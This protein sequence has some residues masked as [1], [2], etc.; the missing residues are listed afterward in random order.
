[1]AWSGTT[2]PDNRVWVWIDY[3]PINGDTPA[4]TY[5]AADITGAS[6]A[7]DVASTSTRGFFVTANPATVTAT[8]DNPPAKFNWCA[9]GSGAPPKAVIINADGDYSLKGTPPFTVNGT[10][11]GAD[12]TTFGAGTCITSITDLTGNPAGLIPDKPTVSTS[13]PA[14]R[15]GAGAVTLTAT[16]SGGVTTAMTY[17]WIVGGEPAETTADGSQTTAV[18]GSTTYSVTATNANGCT[19]AAATGTITVNPL[20]ESLSLT[21]SPAAI[22][23]GESTTLTASA[24][25]AASYSL[26]GS[27]WQTTNTFVVSP[28]ETTIY[29]LY[30]RTSAGC[31]ASKTTAATVTVNP[32]PESLSLTAST[33]T[34]CI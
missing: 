29:T 10:T 19:S 33:A 16:A 18:A 5:G 32:L 28:T 1:V 26:D 13:N 9:Y 34:I 27:A 14:A 6:P 23:N 8:L 25:D 12:V 24:S 2:T 7:A 20:P 15:C 17:T 30:G 11:L 4:G 3:C 31:T 21:A 22:C